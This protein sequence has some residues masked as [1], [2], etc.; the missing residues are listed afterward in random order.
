MVLPVGLSE[1]AEFPGLLRAGCWHLPISVRGSQRRP[2]SQG[3]PGEAMRPLVCMKLPQI[4]QDNKSE[5]WYQDTS[6]YT[7][8]RALA[9]KKRER[10]TSAEGRSW[11]LCSVHKIP[12][13]SS[14]KFDSPSNTPRCSRQKAPPATEGRFSICWGR[15]PGSAEMSHT[16][17]D[18]HSQRSPRKMKQPLLTG[19]SDLEISCSHLPPSAAEPP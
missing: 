14:G 10:R 17:C 8:M 16:Q 6:F 1:N 9:P 18:F 7:L 19:R 13:L 4:W 15:E 12:T 5:G 11:I 3:G 2:W